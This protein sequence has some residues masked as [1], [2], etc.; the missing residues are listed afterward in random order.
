MIR[1][2]LVRALLAVLTLLLPALVAGSAVVP[3]S[4]APDDPPE[5]PPAP[6]G[7]TLTW[8]ALG[9]QQQAYL[10]TDGSHSFTV[11]VPAGLSAVRLR[12]LIHAPLNIRAGFMEITDGE[13]KFLSAVDLPPQSSA[14]PVVPFD[15][16]I[17]PARV[18]NSSID[19]SFTVRPVDA[20]DQ[21]CGPR[22]Q[23]IISDLSMVYAGAEPPV[24]TVGNFF[25]PVLQRITIYSPTD[26]DAAEKQ[27]VLALVATLARLYQPQPLSIGVVTQ[28]RGATP[29]P[30]APLTRSVVVEKGDTGVNV[31]NPGNPDAYLRVSGR[32][33][34]LT[35]Q[36]SLFVN[37]LQTLV[38]TPGV[39]VDQAGAPATLSGDT[40]T[41]SQLR[42][43]GRTDILKSA[44][45]SVGVDRAA[46]GGGRVDS[47]Q[48]H[49]LGD[50]TPVPKEDA[51]SMV[52]RSNGI[53]VYR[54]ALDNSGVV[55]ATF[56]L[57]NPT[58]GQRFGLDFAL[59]YTPHESC[60]PLLVPIAFQIDP[61]STVTITRGGPPLGGF[62]ALP[63][64]FD[65]TFMVAFD[66][67]SPNQ[68]SYAARVVGAI[69]RLTSRQ[70]TPQVVD[71]KTAVDANSGAL[72]VARSSAIGQTSLSPPVGGDGTSV[73][74]ALPT[75]LRANIDG[76]IG[77]IQSFAD[78]SRD[79]TVVL[80]T[81]TSAWT[82]V[83]PLFDY[84]E[85]LNGGWSALTGDV[86]AAGAAGVPVNVAV[87]GADNVFLPPSQGWNRWVIIGVVVALAA[88]IAILAAT[89]WSSRRRTNDADDVAAGS[90][91]SPERQ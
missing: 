90:V 50:Y 1:G 49:L 11:P 4:A 25:P 13:G 80:V 31:L 89:L 75:E 12:G 27:S 51:A 41:F 73:N 54:A 78:R 38:Q 14:Q 67:S 82:L 33:D 52:V 7:V 59:T 44:S 88:A 76:G 15:V 84:I 26:A 58:L 5:P 74:V 46:L 81:T 64:E 56:E 53:V 83:D 45:L 19:L 39:R 2:G 18:R 22:Q 57:S 55:D 28:P 72:I 63:S 10:G 40:L 61:R 42:M 77:S 34:A 62:S 47:V 87:R 32:G 35:A 6:L 85:G 30:F 21:I 70:L 36:A 65:P 43:N 24:T 66:G 23:V 8:T 17:A 91:P 16:D 86:L 68:L 71:L 20:S 79:R 37:Q 48:V 9:L 3:A 29:P 60:G 69:A